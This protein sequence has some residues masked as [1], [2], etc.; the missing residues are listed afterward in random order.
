MCTVAEWLNAWADRLKADVSTAQTYRSHV[1]VHLIPHLG[2]IVSDLGDLT[3]THQE[4]WRTYEVSKVDGLEPHPVWWNAQVRGAWPTGCAP[5]SACC[6]SCERGTSSTT[7][8]SASIL[9]GRLSVPASSV[10]SCAR[11]SRKYDAFIHLLDK[12]LSENL[13][14]DAFDKTGIAKQGKNGQN[15]GRLSRLDRLLENNAVA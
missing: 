10:G 1:Q 14:H 12:L 6:S 7:T 3:P 13:R 5:S 9:C 11:R 15:L 2:N 4:R 8:C